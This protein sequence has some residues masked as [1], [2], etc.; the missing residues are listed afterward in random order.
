LT[1]MGHSEAAAWWEHAKRHFDVPGQSQARADEKGRTWAAHIYRRDDHR[2]LV[3][4]APRAL[5]RPRPAPTDQLT[6]A[7]ND[8]DP[9]Q[10]LGV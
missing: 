2:I 10:P 7:F 1:W 5:G 4:E 3:V 8:L 9:G 6:T